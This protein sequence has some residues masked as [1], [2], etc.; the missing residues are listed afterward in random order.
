MDASIRF[1]YMLS[2]MRRTS[3]FASVMFFAGCVQVSSPLP[4]LG[5]GAATGAPRP[6]AAR[7]TVFIEE[8]TWM[9][10]RDALRAGATTVLVPTGG[11]E[12]SGPYLATGKHNYIL[13]ATSDTIARKLGNTLVAP[14][15]PFV[16][17]GNINPPSE[18][19]RYP[20]TISVNS[21]TFQRLLTDICASLNAHGFRRIILIGDSEWNQRDMEVVAGKLDAAWKGTARVRCIPE[22]YD[23]PGVT[24]WLEQQGVLQQD[25]GLHDDFV[26]TAQLMAVDPTTVRME[27]R[28]AA[29]K[30]RINGI[31]L[32]PAEKTIEWGR[33]II[34]FR[35]DV[36]V[37]AIRKQ[38]GDGTERR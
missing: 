3:V 30:F 15:V 19:M 7:D 36:T 38:M 22:Y 24:R 26:T 9:E 12:Q 8:M 34:Q 23:Y 37:R 5:A 28:L 11:V 4:E 13:R 10:V 18:H 25:E 17:E 33:R 29:G 35:A 27:E 16:P 14:I 6:I 21:E 32:V 1:A 2:F 20:G 31:D